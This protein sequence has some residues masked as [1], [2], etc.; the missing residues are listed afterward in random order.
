[1]TV[2]RCM[3]KRR[4]EVRKIGS[5]PDIKTIDEIAQRVIAGLVHGRFFLLLDEV[6][7]KNQNRAFD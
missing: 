3:S 7:Q 2:G 1:M 4:V 6:K 5:A